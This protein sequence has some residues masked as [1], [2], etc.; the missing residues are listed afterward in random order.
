VS[1]FTC[2][3]R[4][5]GGGGGGFARQPRAWEEMCFFP[6]DLRVG[7]E[8]ALTA[9][10]KGKCKA[11]LVESHRKERLQHFLCGERSGLSSRNQGVCLYLYLDIKRITPVSL[12]GIHSLA[13]PP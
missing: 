5:D 7:H 10:A 1:P 11:K 6:L 2:R 8:G 13:N 3:H 12:C 9:R 4:D